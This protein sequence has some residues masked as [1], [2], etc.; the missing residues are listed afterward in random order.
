MRFVAAFLAFFLFN[1]FL[2]FGF[3]SS[4]A[5]GIWFWYLADLAIKSNTRIAFREYILVMYG[6]NYLFASALQ[7]YA[8]TQSISIYRMRIP[9]DEY[10]A[11]AIPSMFCFHLGL[12]MFKTKV[13]E[14]NFNL[15]A[16]QSRLN[17]NVLRQ[18]LIVGIA[19]NIIR[20]F[21]PG[22]LSYI[23]YLLAGIR[24]VALFGLFLIDRKK[25]KWYLY[26]LLFLEVAAALREGMFH[27][28]VIWVVF[29]GMFWTYLKKPSA[30]TKAI[31]G[32]AV[33]LCLY[34][35]QITKAGYREKLH[36]G[37]GSGIGTFSTAL[38]NNNKGGGVFSMVNFTESIVRA[39]QGWIFASSVNRMNRIKDYQGLAVVKKYAEAAFLP[40]FLAPDK[41]Q[42]GD[43]AIFNRFSGVTILGNT[44]MG[45]GIFADGYIGY[46]MYGSLIFAF[47]FGLIVAYVF[48]VVER[49]SRISPFFIFF[50]YVILNYAV[51]A[52]CE[53]QT[54][55]THLVKGLIIF[56]LIMAYYKRY[57]ARQS[58]AAE[59][60]ARVFKEAL[61]ASPA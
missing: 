5:V 17:Q 11:L 26:V 47:V 49:W 40:R 53:T 6:L 3:W 29:F 27:D 31:L 21:F 42:A 59:E 9:E 61:V 20:P 38:A 8:P 2:E 35:L 48:K 41:I 57:F 4:A 52:D 30:G 54:M 44:S 36:S 56:G 32:V 58:V 43:K 16:I 14:P 60:Q 37:G 25:Y 33:V 10:F 55:M 24:Y 50:F 7:Y 28:L 12:Y 1:S 39:N 19:L 34:F 45:L 13:F 51:R 23:I 46:G 22:E 18:W 15:T